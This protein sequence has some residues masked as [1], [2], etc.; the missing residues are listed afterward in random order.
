MYLTY[1]YTYYFTMSTNPG[2]FLRINREKKN[3]FCFVFIFKMGYFF[4]FFLFTGIIWFRNAQLPHPF[5]EFAWNVFK[6]HSKRAVFSL[7][8][9][10]G[11]IMLHD[12]LTVRTCP[13]PL[14]VDDD[15]LLL[16]KVNKRL[17]NNFFIKK[18]EEPTAME[19]LK[20]A[21]KYIL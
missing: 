10:Q 14:V 4:C 19:I 2:N 18:N 11:R 13:C 20:S 17:E 3:L 5:T 9:A 21:Q 15:E 16:K 1:A 7:P 6:L 8:K 12:V